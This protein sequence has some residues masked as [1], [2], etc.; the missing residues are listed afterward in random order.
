MPIKK[1]VSTGTTVLRQHADSWEDAVRQ[2]GGLLEKAG[3]IVPDY[4]NAMI[5]MVKE[6]GP[7]IVVMPGVALAHARPENHVK[8]NSIAVVTYEEGICFGNESNDPV[9]IVFAIAACSDDEHLDLFQ[10]V[11]GF[12]AEESNV[13]RLKHAAV[14]EEIGF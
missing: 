3:T 11:A 2:A 14:Y 13:E 4:T 9:Y 1:Y 12:I 6:L 10:A 8:Q 7:Y 5:R